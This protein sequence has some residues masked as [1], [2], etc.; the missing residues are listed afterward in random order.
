[1]CTAI[2]VVGTHYFSQGARSIV[3]FVGF[4]SPPLEIQIHNRRYTYRLLESWAT[5]PGRLSAGGK[6]WRVA[7][8]EPIREGECMDFE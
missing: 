2:R 6:E 8:G 1:M 4:F 7:T 5:G 3:E